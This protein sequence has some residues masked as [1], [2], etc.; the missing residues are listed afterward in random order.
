MF[1]NIP[2]PAVDPLYK[3]VQAFNEDE[4]S[5]KVDLGVGVYKDAEGKAS[6]MRC[7]AEAE[8]DLAESRSTKAYL[9]QSG[10]PAFI[11]GMTD[12]LFGEH[13]RP[14]MARIQT[15][16]GTG[17][18]RLALEAAKAADPNCKAF[19]GVP[20][21]PNH[22]AICDVLDIRVETF[23]YR[24]QDNASAS[25][26][27]ALEA[28]GRANPGDI[29]ILHGPCHNPTGLDYSHIE[30]FALLDAA[31][32]KGIVPLIDA[33]YY[34]LGS[35]LSS[36]LNEMRSMLAYMPEV[37]LVMSCSKAFGLY[38]DRIGILFAKTRSRDVAGN[39]QA[40]LQITARV[41]YSGPAAHGGEVV[42]HILSENKRRDDWMSELAEM[43]ERV[44]GIRTR[45]AQLGRGLPALEAVA[46]GK[47][48]FAMLPL[49]A[50][51][52]FVLA[53]DHA[54]FMPENGRV[55]LAGLRSED[56]DRFV[57]A[58]ADQLR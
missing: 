48:I 6:I 15:I 11:E 27:N 49:T 31:A 55:N 53:N 38:R 26:D 13:D 4:R 16:G 9:P 30:L 42:G 44:S 22:A 39:L 14:N 28:L 29:L 37:M 10:A 43:R 5:N 56:V 54:I 50:E 51:D 25:L 52:T 33:A 23:A 41:T 35:E 19:L 12:L 20:S 1:E 24:T 17:G 58:V 36:D 21:W 57:E 7:V 46:S 18:V 34:G 47:G 32:S 3:V 45:M 8:A 2:S 40:A